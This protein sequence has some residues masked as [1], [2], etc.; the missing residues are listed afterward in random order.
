MTM[1]NSPI[2]QAILHGRFSKDGDVLKVAD[3]FKEWKERAFKI[4]DRQ[5]EEIKDLIIKI[6]R[7]SSPVLD[8]EKDKRAFAAL[9]DAKPDYSPEIRAGVVE[10]LV[11]IGV[12]PDLLCNCSKKNGKMRHLIF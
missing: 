1:K 8:L 7:S 2:G 9:Y 4:F 6:L 11:Y 12:Y 3:H 5:L 10:T